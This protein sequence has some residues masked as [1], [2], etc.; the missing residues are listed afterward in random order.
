MKK[1]WVAFFIFWPTVAV[2]SF[3]VA[4][5]RDWWFPYGAESAAPLGQQID[6]LFYMI[7]VITG[8]VFIATQVALGYIL[9]RGARDTDEEA[10]FTHG[11]HNLEVIWTIVPAGILLFIALYQMDVW[12]QYRVTSQFPEEARTAPVAEVTARQFEW[13]IRYPSPETSREL[14]TEADVRDWLRNPRPDDLHAVNELHVPTHRP[15]QIR[16]RTEDVQHSFFVPELRVKQDAVPG[17]IIPVWFEVENRKPY[18]DALGGVSYHFLCAEL[19]GWGH[20]KMGARLIA[21]PQED[22]EAFLEELEKQQFD[23]GVPDKS[24]K[25][26]ESDADESSND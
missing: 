14:K 22:F 3:V 26:D 17:L 5:G 6:N 1:F 2:L 18:D 10:V 13:R 19:C 12:A 8:A 25:T 15:V 11:N 4:P 20:Y 24:E 23:D 9:W 16:L 21:Q 7:L